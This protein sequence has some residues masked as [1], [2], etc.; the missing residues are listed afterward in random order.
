MFKNKID[1]RPALTAP[2][3]GGRPIRDHFLQNILFRQRTFKFLKNAIAFQ[4]SFDIK[5]RFCAE[6]T[7]VVHKNL[8]K[9]GL[10]VYKRDRRFADL[11]HHMEQSAIRQ[12]LQ[13][14][15]VIIQARAFLYDTRWK[16]LVFFG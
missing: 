9:T 2:I 11:F 15:F 5:L 3:K 6:Q 13:R 1:L 10:I 8:K 7:Y 16:F 4:Q 12:P 14:K